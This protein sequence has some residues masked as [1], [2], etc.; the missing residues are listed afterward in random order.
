MRSCTPSKCVESS[1]ALGDVVLEVKGL[2]NGRCEYFE[3]TPFMT[4][5]CMF[6]PD[7]RLKMA[8]FQEYYRK[9]QGWSSGSGVE[10]F[11]FSNSPDCTFAS[12]SVD[13]FGTNKVE[14]TYLEGNPFSSPVLNH[15][16]FIKDVDYYTGDD[17][18]KLPVN[19]SKVDGAEL[20]L[21]SSFDFK[22]EGNGL[23]G[24]Q[25]LN[26]NNNS[27]RYVD[28]SGEVSFSTPGAYS[29]TVNLYDCSKMSDSEKSEFKCGTDKVMSPYSTNVKP[30]RSFTK[31]FEF[32]DFNTSPV[33]I[34][35]SEYLGWTYQSNSNNTAA[36]SQV[37]EVSY[38]YYG[39]FLV[40]SS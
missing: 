17:V 5:T 2:K 11:D 18:W 1:T 30:F 15:G 31:Y 28:M 34:T 12:G 13:L 33:E 16:Q 38:S 24:G 23:G 20:V 36:S 8:D 32:A 40:V 14:S 37:S 6:T 10:Y 26:K 21:S 9:N 3:D 27:D 35:K 29:L 7:D 39:S 22:F 4:M 19:V 25:G